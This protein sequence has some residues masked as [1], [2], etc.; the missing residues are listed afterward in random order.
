MIKTDRISKENLLA[1]F[2]RALITNY[3][4]K[5]EQGA[6]SVKFTQHQQMN[7]LLPLARL[8]NV[9]CGE[10]MRWQD[11]LLRLSEHLTHKENY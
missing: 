5:L 1:D 6:T 4:E 8:N 9:P 7:W 2:G 11:L 3:L 10:D